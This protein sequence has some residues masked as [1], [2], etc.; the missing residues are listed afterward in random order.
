[1]AARFD[2]FD[3]LDDQGEVDRQSAPAVATEL[4]QPEAVAILA[5]AADPGLDRRGVRVVASRTHVEDGLDDA[6]KVPLDRARARGG[7][8]A[9]AVVLPVETDGANATP[10]GVTV[11]AVRVVHCADV[12]HGAPPVGIAATA[13]GVQ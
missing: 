6:G 13:A 5:V 8:A 12:R 4:A 10:E 11:V 2:L 1:M 3:R 9:G 7:E